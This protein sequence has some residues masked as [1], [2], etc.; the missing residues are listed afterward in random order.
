ML[1][2]PALVRTNG[3]RRSW[4]EEEEED[5]EEA[6]A[7]GGV[8][9]VPAE[10]LTPFPCGLFH[11]LQVN[12]CRWS[13]QQKPEDDDVRLWA[14]G[15]RLSQ[16]R[17]EVLVLLVN[18]GQGVELR[19][20]GPDSE[21]ASCYMLLDLISSMVDGLL[22]TTLP[23]LMTV[24][25]YLSPQQ[26][27]EHHEPIMVYQPRDFFRA[28]TQ[29]ETSL[30]NTMAGYKESFSSILTFGCTEVYQQASLGA[31]IHASD[32]S[33]LARRK[34]CR[35]LDPPDAMGK[36][37]CLLAMNLGLTELVAKFSTTN[38]TPGEEGASLPSPMALLLR[39]WS[40]RPDSTVGILLA[41]LREL[42]RRDAA[43]F[44][45]KVSPVFRVSP[46]GA[47]QESYRTICN[48]GTSH[49]SIS[50]VISR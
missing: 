14:N 6:L 50:S 31:D 23:G 29:R 30:A 34:L 37:W 22:A 47:S 20:R 13:H 44:L 39:E 5:G 15:V 35:L 8:R 18:H 38:G 25:H 41:K 11:K 7:Y 3:L 17:A 45:L 21:R 42:G 2:I 28:Q 32:I 4:T 10:H 19:V 40:G 46:E 49:N 9:V 33:L 24:K 27:R 36:D 1:D 12:L 26:L 43:D 48:G 16:G